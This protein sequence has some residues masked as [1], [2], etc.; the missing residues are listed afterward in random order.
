MIS[1]SLVKELREKT[2]AGMMD[3]KKVLTETNGDMEKASELL[4]ERG[5][6][7]AAKKSERIAAEGL[8][9]AYVSED[10][11]VGAVVEVNAETDF[12]A[13]NAEFQKFVED[14]TMTVVK[15][16]PADVADLL[17]KTM[18]ETG[19]TVEATLTDK[20]ATIGENMSIRRF[21][22]F[23]SQGLV[24]SYIHGNGKIG[25]LV[26]IDV[27]NSELAKDICMQIAAARPEYLDR[28]QV[29][30]EV[31]NKEMEILKAQAM[32]E[33]KPEAIAEKI[34]NGR[35]QKFYSEICLVDQAFVKNP[36]IKISQL[37]KEN[38][39]NINTYARFEKGE[40]LEK[41]EENFA[42]EVMKQIK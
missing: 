26:D 40:G 30:A 7:K 20:I 39:A 21:A 23:E 11:K 10:K 38:N 36:D 14:V 28:T 8:V 9:Y 31:L 37:L 16:N 25:V 35:I 27:E 13:K 5:I 18:T 2:G 15:E 42:E 12:V 24:E 22:R 19:K 29:P 17:T 41:R 3:C 32:N 33:G 4:R 1:A 6:A 34:V